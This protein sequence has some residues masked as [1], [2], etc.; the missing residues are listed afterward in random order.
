MM[1]VPVEHCER[2]EPQ[3]ATTPRDFMGQSFPRKKSFKLKTLYLFQARSYLDK[4]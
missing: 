2:L 1:E 4:A 3:R